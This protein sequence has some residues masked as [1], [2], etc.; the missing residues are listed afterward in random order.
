MRRE[1][2]DRWV[3]ALGSGEYRQ[4]RQ[5]LRCREPGGDG[6]EYCCLGVLLDLVDPGG[7]YPH[8]DD[9]GEEPIPH[10]LA[11]DHEELSQLG[12]ERVGLPG[13]L[14]TELIE[15][16]DELQRSFAEIAEVI[17]ARLRV[18]D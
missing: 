8:Y 11:T 5:R 14:Q 13:Y 15:L 3:A 17:A 9:G 16:N 18:T 7:W 6:Y 2:R 1:L 4:G 12:L 10:T